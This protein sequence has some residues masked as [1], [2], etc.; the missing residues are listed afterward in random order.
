MSITY[1]EICLTCLVYAMQFMMLLLVGVLFFY[2]DEN[3]HIFKIILYA[4]SAVSVTEDV[5]MRLVPKQFYVFP[6]T[7]IFKVFNS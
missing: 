4:K 1:F 6:F 5:Y 7:V 3:R 2:D